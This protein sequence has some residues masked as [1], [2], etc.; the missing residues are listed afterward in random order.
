MS[1]NQLYRSVIQ[2]LER[3]DFQQTVLLVI[4]IVAIGI[5]CLRGF[6]SRHNY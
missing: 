4:V 6:G 5:Y 2:P 3:L 1:F